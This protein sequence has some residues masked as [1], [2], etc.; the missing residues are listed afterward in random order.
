MVSPRVQAHHCVLVSLKTDDMGLQN[1]M[2]LEMSLQI[3]GAGGS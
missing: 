2:I 3:A 1:A